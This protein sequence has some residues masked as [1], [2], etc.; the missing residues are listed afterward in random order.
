MRRHGKHQH[1]GTFRTKAEAAAVADA[2]A[3]AHYGE[4]YSGRTSAER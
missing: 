1:L 4:F 3:S 2:A